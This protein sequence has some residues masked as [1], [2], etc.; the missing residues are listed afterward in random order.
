[1]KNNKIEI[2][3]PISYFD[4][5]KAAI[6]AKTDSI[7]FGIDVLNMRKGATKKF[8]L[9]DI[10]KISTICKENS[11]KCYLTLNSIIY[12]EELEL[13]KQILDESKK[14]NIDAIIAHDF[15]VIEYAKKIGLK[16]H[17]STQA[18]I[19]NIEAVK[20]F[21]K[22]SDVIVLA[23]ELDL[24]QIKKIT[25]EIKNQNILGPSKKPVKIE[26]FAHGALCVAISGKCY[27]SLHQYNKSANRGECL[28]ACRRKYKVEEIET[29]KQLEIDN[30]YILSPK[31]IC[32]IGSI[33]KLIESGVSILK[34]EG[35]ARSCEY[36]YAVTKCYKEATEAY[37][38]NT[39]T[40]E[41]IDHWINELSKVYNRGFWH[42]GYYLGNP[43]DMWSKS[44]GS[45]AKEKKTFLGIA[46]NYFSKI[47]VAEFLLQSHQL[48]IDD[49]ILIFGKTTGMIKTTVRSIHTDKP[50][51]IAHKGD[52]IAIK[53]D[54]KIKKND[55]LYLIEKA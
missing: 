54:K 50:V 34:I 25:Q 40:K 12:D 23:R 2:L 10:Q 47:A 21:S 49:E 45:K 22:F 16:I 13:L 11:I 44:Y 24:D 43:S 5:L 33:D 41:K 55:K 6:D 3:S 14:S 7:Y 51:K 9:Q 31:D 15:A 18:N 46:T 32:T 52:L 48:K 42:G 39:Y 37:F 20:Y 1:M 29:Q 27:M 30:E 17:I 36:V 26:I 35:R 4:S 28:Q 19:S 53:L 8:T 38:N